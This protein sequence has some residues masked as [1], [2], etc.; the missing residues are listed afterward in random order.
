M[1]KL[2]AFCT[3]YSVIKNAFVSSIKPIDATPKPL[4]IT[5]NHEYEKES[6]YTDKQINFVTVIQKRY[7][8]YLS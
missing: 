4:S 7:K 6:E 5:E 3:D 8:L 2:F 1:L